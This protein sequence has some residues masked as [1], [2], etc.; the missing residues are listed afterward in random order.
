MTTPRVRTIAWYDGDTIQSQLVAA[1]APADTL[2]AL[3]GAPGSSDQDQ[4][5]QD[6]PQ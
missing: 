5:E 3:T 4:P 6:G 1:P 2:T